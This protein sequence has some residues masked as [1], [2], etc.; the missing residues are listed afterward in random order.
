MPSSTSNH[1]TL[2]QHAATTRCNNTLQQHAATTR[3][4][5][6]LQQHA[7]TTRCNTLQDAARHLIFEHM[8]HAIEHLQAFVDDVYTLVDLQVFARVFENGLPDLIFPEKL[9]D[10]SRSYV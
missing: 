8:E 4:N 1:N 9:C 10:V 5:N 7:V 2:Q 6:T 3:C